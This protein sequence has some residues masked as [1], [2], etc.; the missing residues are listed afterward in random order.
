[1]K[2]KCIPSK[3]LCQGCFHRR[4]H[5][6]TKKN[7]DPNGKNISQNYVDNLINFKN[8]ILFFFSVLN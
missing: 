4:D 2:N 3:V 6:K 8:G 5:I 1:M 7:N